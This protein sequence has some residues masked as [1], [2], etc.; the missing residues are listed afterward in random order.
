MNKM[1]SL[2]GLKWNPFAPDLPVE[3]LLITPEAEGFCWRVENLAREGGFALITGE[4]GSGKSVAL[5]VL[6]ERLSALRDV[7]VGVLLRP[8]ANLADFYRELGDLFGIPLSPHNRWGG[9][10]ALRAKWQAHLDAA[11]FRAVLVIDEAQEMLPVVMN[12]LRLMVSSRL[13]SHPLLAVVF[14]GDRRLVERLRTEDLLPLGSRVRVRLALERTTP[15]ELEKC[16]RNA[17][18]TAGAPKL[19]TTELVTTLCEHAAGNYRAMMTLAGELLAA[20]AQRGARELDEKLFLE[21]F[22]V[23]PPPEARAHPRSSQA[24]SRGHRR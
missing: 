18:A 14:A 6:V 13:D 5:R 21:S 12:E 3:G 10:K 22:A 9:S 7:K 24:T 11:L 8:Q 23:P 2:Y 20:G 15:E 1:L 4:P 17:L 19:M 16:L